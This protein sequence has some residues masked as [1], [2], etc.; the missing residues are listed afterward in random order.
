MTGLRERG[1]GLIPSHLY[2]LATTHVLV[3]TIDTYVNKSN[4]N[5]IHLKKV[6]DIHQSFS[7]IRK[8]D[9]L[10]SCSCIFQSPY[11]CGRKYFFSILKSFHAIIQKFLVDMW[12]RHPYFIKMTVKTVKNMLF[13]KVENGNWLVLCGYNMSES[14]SFYNLYS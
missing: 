13:F 8:F 3:I 4:S 10:G 2:I 11:K 14:S 9:I 7:K 1:K 5:I 12:W 6:A